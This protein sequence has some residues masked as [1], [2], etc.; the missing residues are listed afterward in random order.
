MGE[1]TITRR[2]HIAGLTAQVTSS[3]VKDRLGSFGKVS[4]VEDVAVD[5]L[6]QSN[7]WRCLESAALRACRASAALYV[8]DSRDDSVTAQ[9]VCVGHVDPIA[10]D[11]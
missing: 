2:L 9:E 1:P 10:E 7:P 6:G 8:F 5:A 11:C 3:H 4:E